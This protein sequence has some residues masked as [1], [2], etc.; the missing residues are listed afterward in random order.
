MSKGRP[1]SQEYEGN[2]ERSDYCRKRRHRDRRGQLLLPPLF[3]QIGI[4]ARER[5]PYHLP[6]EGRSQLLRPHCRRCGQSRCGLVLPLR[7][8]QPR[9]RLPTA[10]PSGKASRSSSERRFLVPLVAQGRVQF[11]F[12]FPSPPLEGERVRV[13]GAFPTNEKG[14]VWGGL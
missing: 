12:T 5:H 14:H 8:R 9:S 4:P 2:L 11:F 13:R 7:Q 1:G 3:G 10:S 6:L